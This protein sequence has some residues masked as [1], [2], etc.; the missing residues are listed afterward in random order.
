MSS[1][2]LKWTMR[3]FISA[4]LMQIIL[5]ENSKYLALVSMNT[6]SCLLKILSNW[7]F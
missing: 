2:E 5:L 4:Y 1:S 3:N 6:R 7:F